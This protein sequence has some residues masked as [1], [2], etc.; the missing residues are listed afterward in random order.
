MAADSTDAPGDVIVGETPE[1]GGVSELR[2]PVAGR[3]EPGVPG[4]AEPGVPEGMEQQV[5]GD[6][7]EQQSEVVVAESKDI[8]LDEEKPERVTA[9][10]GQDGSLAVGEGPEARLAAEAEGGVVRSKPESHSVGEEPTSVVEDSIRKLQPFFE[11]KTAVSSV[12][13]MKYMYM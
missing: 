8:Q 2:Q 6:V 10:P 12:K 5:A 3:V 9:V 1:E 11:A 7:S 4:R 13:N